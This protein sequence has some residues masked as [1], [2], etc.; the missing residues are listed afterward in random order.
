MFAALGAKIHGV[1]GKI[2][3]AVMA[4]LS[5]TGMLVYNSPSGFLIAILLGV[6]MRIPHP[7][8]YDNTPL[9]AKRRVIAILTLLIFILCF[10]PFPLQIT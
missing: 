10:V 4:L 9:D 7:E 6:M 1:T 8:P 5:V 2:A 3:F